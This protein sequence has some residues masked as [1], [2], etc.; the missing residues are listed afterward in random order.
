MAIRMIV[1]DLDGTMLGPD[2]KIPAANREAVRRAAAAGVKVTLATGRMYC[3]ALPYAKTLDLDTPIISYNG[4]L[5]RTA[6]GQVLS[7]N[8]LAPETVTRALEFAFARNWYVQLYQDDTLYYAAAT[9]EA[10]AYEKSSGIPGHAVGND[11]LL[12]RTE[13]VSKLLLVMPSPDLVPV[14]V[15]ALNSALGEELTAMRSAPTYIEVI[16][17]GV[18]KAASMLALARDEGIAPEEIMALG[19]S[20]NDISML[21]AAGLGVAMAIAGDEVKR[22]ADRIEDS[23][24]AAISR[25]VLGEE[26]P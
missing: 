4:A 18:S 10:L 5:V 2:Y 20:N 14:A 26:T 9:P 22:A 21:R 15:D 3:S 12:A 23:V 1:S 16:R 25:Y 19:D 24:A 17:P 13:R 7:D 11:G 8:G 6:G